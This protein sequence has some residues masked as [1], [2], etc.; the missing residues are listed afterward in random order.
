MNYNND[1]II[2]KMNN[3]EFNLYR[4]SEFFY[5]KLPV[6]FKNPKIRKE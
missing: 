6:S 4:P 3:Y 2:K 5:I 1:Y